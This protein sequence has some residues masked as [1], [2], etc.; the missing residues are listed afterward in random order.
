[1]K[2]KLL[3]EVVFVCCA[4]GS[5]Q[6]LPLFGPMPVMYFATTSTGIYNAPGL[7][8]DVPDMSVCGVNFYNYM[9]G[10][11][12]A[13]Y[14][15]TVVAQPY[16]LRD[17][18][19]TSNFFL[20]KVSDYCDF[21]ANFGHGGPGCI[22]LYGYSRIYMYCGKIDAIPGRVRFGGWTKW[23]IFNSCK[24]LEYD[25]QSLDGTYESGGYQLNNYVPI[26]GGPHAFAGFQ[27]NTKC[28]KRYCTKGNIGNW[29]GGHWTWGNNDVWFAFAQNFINHN[30]TFSAAW[31]NATLT[32]AQK[33]AFGIHIRVL[34]V[35][36]M[37]NKNGIWT[38]YDGTQECY[39][40][41]L[42]A[43]TPI[44][45]AN[46][47]NN[48]QGTTISSYWLQGSVPVGSAGYVGTVLQLTPGPAMLTTKYKLT[49]NDV[50]YGTP[51]YS[52]PF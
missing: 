32:A 39:A 30:Q 48:W 23:V 12:K 19:V 7:A 24:T 3:L 40:T 21:Y 37:V 18:Q 26:C 4:M 36:G 8:E 6:G 50:I 29:C 25:P 20:N 45:D 11:I 33:I 47:V 1:M 46:N 13:K 42:Q 28:W 17:A 51:S 15:S 27:S 14:P 2:R 9:N 31:I 49:S 44:S 16:D 41:A 22:T 35:S 43:P 10:A 52:T 38:P 34:G 5:A